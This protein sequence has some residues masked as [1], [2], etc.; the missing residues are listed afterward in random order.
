[1]C[2]RCARPTWSAI[3]RR[4][5]G[6]SEKVTVTDRGKLREPRAIQRR[7]TGAAAKPTA[8]DRSKPGEPRAIQR[9]QPGAAVKPTV[10]DRS[11]LGEPRAIQRRQ[12][13]AAA[14]PTATDRRK[15]HEPRANPALS[16]LCSREASH[17][18]P[19]YPAPMN[20]NTRTVRGNIIPRTNYGCGTITVNINYKADKL[21]YF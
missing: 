8:A 17:H 14:K 15:P 10:T 3:Q 1:M 2:A 5:A 13:G 9:R 7:Q 18:Q 6:A 4:Q 19:C 21:P 12:T 16:K 20:W 11:Q